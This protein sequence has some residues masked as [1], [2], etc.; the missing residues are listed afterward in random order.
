MI[1]LFSICNLL[2]SYIYIRKYGLFHFIISSTASKSASQEY[3]MNNEV[4]FCAQIFGLLINNS[5]KYATSIIALRLSTISY[6]LI[7]KL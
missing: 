7:I 2:L 3:Y 6:F 5:K 1:V 4:L